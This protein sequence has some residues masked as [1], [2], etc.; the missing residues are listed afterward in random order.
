MTKLECRRRFRLRHSRT[1]LIGW[2]K[3]VVWLRRF[4]SLWICF[5][6]IGDF[7][8]RHF[9]RPSTFVQ[10]RPSRRSTD[11][12]QPNVSDNDSLLI[13]LPEIPLAMICPFFM[14]ST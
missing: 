5:F 3:V 8:I 7:V 13:T 2:F 14:S 4:S 10:Y 9:Y 11:T 12:L 1:A 6:V